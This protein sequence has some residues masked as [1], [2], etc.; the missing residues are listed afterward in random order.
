MQDWHLL[1][2]KWLLLRKEVG[3]VLSQY[4][5]TSFVFYLSILRQGFLPLK[6]KSKIYKW[7]KIIST[8]LEDEGLLVNEEES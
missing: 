1:G 4:H 7:N 3:Y 2:S 5:Y 8:L 6:G